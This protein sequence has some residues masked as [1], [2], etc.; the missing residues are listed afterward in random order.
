VHAAQRGEEPVQPW[1]QHARH[2][3]CLLGRVHAHRHGLRLL[4]LVTRAR[5]RIGKPNQGFK[6][7]GK[8]KLHIN[9][10]RRLGGER[11]RLAG[12]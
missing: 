10:R 4:L 1:Q 5:A 11:G 2:A 3:L 6:Q 12:P 8:A 7:L 9:G